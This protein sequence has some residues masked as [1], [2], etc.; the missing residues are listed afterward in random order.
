[1][2]ETVIDGARITFEERGKGA[3]AILLHGWNGSRKEWLFNLKALAPRFRAIAPD[4]PGFGDSEDMRNF[5]YTLDEAASFLE[6]FRRRLRLQSFHLVG[7][8]MGGSIAAHYAAKHP[9]NV[10]KLVLISTPTRSSSVALRM[11]M[12]GVSQFLSATYRFRSEAILKW[13]F[14]HGLHKPEYQDLDFVRAN[15]QTISHTTKTALIESAR[16]FRKMNL[17]DDLRRINRPTLIVF[18]DKDRTVSTREVALQKKNL[19]QPYVAIITGSGHSPN[20]ERP[21][22]F[23]Q[24]LVDFL[25]EE[26]LGVDI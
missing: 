19:P 3:P 16:L 14:Y 24:L 21:E 1:M 22:I 15:I 11:R 9:G 18:G 12:P 8:S 17:E 25:L 10:R 6:A 7:H 4:L 20:F 26:A 23:N 5:S 13:T 2:A